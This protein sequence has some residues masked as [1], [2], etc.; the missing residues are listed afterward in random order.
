[1]SSVMLSDVLS[2]CDPRPHRDHCHRAPQ[3]HVSGLAAGAKPLPPS[4][5][6]F[7]IA[8]PGLVSTM[9]LPPIATAPTELTALWLRA[10][11]VVDAMSIFMRRGPH[12]Y[13][14]FKARVDA[15]RPAKDSGRDDFVDLCLR[16]VLVNDPPQLDAPHVQAH[17]AAGAAPFRVAIL[18]RLLHHLQVDYGP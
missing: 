11:H 15:D 16:R 2:A 18:H 8:R 17:F 13:V 9:S 14:A 10:H 12:S 7:S 3:P 5:A 1:M 6:L 4:L